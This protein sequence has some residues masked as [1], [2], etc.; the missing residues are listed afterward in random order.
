VLPEWLAYGLAISGLV[1]VLVG[2]LFVLGERLFPTRP[3]RRARAGAGEWKRRQEIR[4]YLRAI[5]EPFAEDHPVAGTPVAF[6]LPGRDVAITFDAPAFFRL[7]AADP[8]VVLAEHEM[9]GSHL[10]SRLPFE[11]P[12]YEDVFEDPGTLAEGVTDPF[13]TLGLAESASEEEV[14]TAYRDR[15]KEVH[16]DH[17][18]DQ[19]AFERV[20]EAY[21]AARQAANAEA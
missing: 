2:V 9:P 8:D 11:T 20:R 12:A 16:P 17:G 13:E 15:V 19:A 7:Q 1:T 18:G 14:K 5:D 10:G 21:A 6:Y 3:V 4:E